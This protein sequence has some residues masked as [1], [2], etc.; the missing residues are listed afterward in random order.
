MLL[1]RGG[2]VIDTEKR[3]EKQADVVIKDGRILGIG[4]FTDD[5]S[6]EQVI[7]ARGWVVAG[8]TFMPA[9]S[10]LHSAI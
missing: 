4:D 9:I 5:G 2:R 6:Y 3:E 7:E 10:F 1:I 8:R